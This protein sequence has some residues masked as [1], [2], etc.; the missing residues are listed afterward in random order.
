M[1]LFFAWLVNLYRLVTGKRPIIRVKMSHFH[2][3]LPQPGA[4]FE[5]HS[6]KNLAGPGIDENIMRSLEMHGQ[7]QKVFSD[8]NVL[9]YEVIK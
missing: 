7:A 4:K 3:G 8:G 2:N 1:K 6:L 5:V 9:T